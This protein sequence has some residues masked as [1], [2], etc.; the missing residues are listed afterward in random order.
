M[1]VDKEVSLIITYPP[2]TNRKEQ[3]RPKCTYGVLSDEQ[4]ELVAEMEA[5][6]STPGVNGHLLFSAYQFRFWARCLE[7]IKETVTYF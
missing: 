3:D 7:R 6:F 5:K 1:G 2:F 4:M